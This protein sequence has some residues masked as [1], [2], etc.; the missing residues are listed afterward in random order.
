LSG[1]PSQINTLKPISKIADR[2][3]KGKAPADEKAQHTWEYV[4]I[5]SR[6]VTPL[7]SVKCIFEIGYSLQTGKNVVD[8]KVLSILRLDAQTSLILCNKM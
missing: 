1:R 3:L 8:F 2:A 4:S 5:L 6:S 7:L